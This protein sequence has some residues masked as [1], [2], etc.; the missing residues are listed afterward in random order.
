MKRR[1]PS[2]SAAISASAETGICLPL[3]V[4]AMVFG[5]SPKATNQMVCNWRFCH[6]P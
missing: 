4:M 2:R 5:R 3:A 6:K 1:N